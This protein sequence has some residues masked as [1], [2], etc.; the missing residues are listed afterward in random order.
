MKFVFS[1]IL[2]FCIFGTS[3]SAQNDAKAKSVLDKVSQFYKNQKSISADFSLNIKNA[4][5]GIN[6]TQKG[7]LVLQGESYKITTSQ[8]VRVCNGSTIWTHF[9]EDEEIQITDY[10]PEEEEMTPAKLFTIYEEGYSYSY[11]EKKE[12]NDI[13]DLIPEDT[14]SPYFKIRLSVNA[15]NYIE[16][17][18]VFS[19]NGTV[20]MY[21]I[22]DMQVNKAIDGGNTFEY[23]TTHVCGDCEVVDLRF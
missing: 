7:S 2:S 17:A 19:R 9:I 23:N 16:S 13:I 8:I 6:E 5:A 18:T 21:K 14:D 1:I 12:G 10:D 3:I 4:D 20:M 11:V 22:N 15:S